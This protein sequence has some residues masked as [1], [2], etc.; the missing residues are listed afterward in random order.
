MS[1]IKYFS[2]QQD[3]FSIQGHMML[4]PK[5]T[6]KADVAV[7]GTGPGGATVARDLTLQGKTVIMLDWGGKVPPN[8]SVVRGAF[9][10][11][12][13]MKMHRGMMVSNQ[14][15]M[16]VRCVTVG[17][18]TQMYTGTAWE[19]PP[20][21]FAKYDIDL[22]A[23]VEEIKRECSVIPIPDHLMGP[24]ARAVMQSA[25]D[26]GYKWEKLSKFLKPE[27]CVTGCN[28]CYFGCRRGAKFHA[29]D[30]VMDAVDHG[31]TLLP[32]TRCEKV[33]QSNG[34]ATGILAVDESGREMIIEAKAVVISAGG[35]G[36][37]VV[38]QKSGIH[39][40]GKNFFF[41]PFVMTYGTV[42]GD[43]LALSKEFAMTAGLHLEEEGVLVT[44]MMTPTAITKVYAAAV[45]KFKALFKTGRQIGLMTKIRDSIDGSISITGRVSKPISE[46]ER[47]LLNKGR[48]IS[49]EVLRHLGATDIWYS[50]QSAA[51]PGGTCR[52]G[53]VVNNRLETA[54]RNLFVCDASVI[55]EPW[56]LPPVMTVLC[57]SRRLSKHLARYL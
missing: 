29:W 43:R 7:V 32:R 42:G 24:G 5:K 57:L 22:S 30:W 15:N 10:Y 51:H 52:I 14:L 25:Q 47:Y 16:M 48:A 37:P 11:T 12:G 35:V 31:A 26:L 28:E 1:G 2:G 45:G 40:A 6:L 19:P 50:L 46:H 54:I 38:L 20:A 41:D 8:G 39:E 56:G 23:E 49:Y 13:G 34:N 55:P 33:I 21:M 18:T 4:K 17:G 36:T 44:D 9:R 53:A 3:C 27:R